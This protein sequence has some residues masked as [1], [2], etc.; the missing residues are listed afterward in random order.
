[1]NWSAVDF[2]WNQARA[3]LATALEGS[4]SAAARKLGQ[5]QPTLSRQVAGLEE[6]LGVTLFE[7]VGKRLVLTETGN[8]LVEHVRAMGEAA[9][10]VALGATGRSEAIVGEVRISVS[11]IVAAYLLPPIVERI[12][13]AY[14]E[15]D[16]HI[17]AS[18]RL[19]DLL[20]READIAI[21]HVRP[22][23][24]DLV[25]RKVRDSSAHFYAAKSYLARHG[26]PESVDLTGAV[27]VG[28]DDNV[29]F[30]EVLGELGARVSPE[31][32]KATTDSHLVGWELVRQGLG[33]G[34]MIRE[35]GDATPEVER[36]LPKLPAIPVPFWLCTH[37]ELATSRRI[38]VTFDLLAQALA[39]NLSTPRPST[40]RK[41]RSPSR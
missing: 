35:V 2:D 8:D 30:A 26:R 15:I 22:E 37:R 10:L 41:R 5:A 13:K 14:P 9:G 6:D 4:L 1:M 28:V 19:S 21:R 33:I 36:V 38:R 25:A 18:N 17:V 11:E 29:R 31:N 39:E 40:R 7:R 34:A 20:R 12:R 3:F 32:F 16:V 23:Q 27:F 24:P